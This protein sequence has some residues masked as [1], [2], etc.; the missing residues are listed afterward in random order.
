MSSLIIPRYLYWCTMSPCWF[1]I[2]SEEMAEGDFPKSMTISF[3]LQTLISKKDALH[4]SVNWDDAA[5]L[6]ASA[7]LSRD[8]ETVFFRQ[9]SK[10]WSPSCQLLHLFV[11]KEFNEGVNRWKKWGCLSKRLSLSHV[12]A[13]WLKSPSA[14]PLD[15][16]QCER[17]EPAC[18]RIWD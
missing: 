4:Q 15:W 3:V 8:T 13:S 10:I 2:E 9:N 14:S 18:K 7:L 6:S 1:S 17:F 16:A 12:G 11:Y 5:L